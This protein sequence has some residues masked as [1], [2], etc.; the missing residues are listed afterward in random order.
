VGAT[1]Q[2]A[3]DISF[4]RLFSTPRRSGAA[5]NPHSYSTQPQLK[6]MRRGLP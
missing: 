5:V 1:L 4:H 2:V 6:P 3:Y